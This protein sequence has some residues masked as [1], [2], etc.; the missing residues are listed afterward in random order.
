MRPDLYYK[1]IHQSPVR[2][3]Y[4]PTGKNERSM[5]RSDIPITV[6]QRFILDYLGN[7]FRPASDI[8]IGFLN[9]ASV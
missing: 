3:I 1:I 6:V 9:V 5:G 8:P 4:Y 7:P 2:G